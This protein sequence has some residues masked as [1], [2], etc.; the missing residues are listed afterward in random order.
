MKKQKWENDLFDDFDDLDD[1][2][3]D[4]GNISH[5]ATNDDC[6]LDDGDLFAIPEDKV[7]KVKLSNDKRIDILEALQKKGYSKE[8]SLKLYTASY[9]YLL[10]QSNNLWNIETIS[11]QID[12]LVNEF[13]SV[14]GFLK[15]ESA[16]SCTNN[17]DMPIRKYT[18]YDMPL[19]DIKDIL[20]YLTLTFS[21]S[22]NEIIEQLCSYPDWFFHKIPYFEKKIKYFQEFFRKDK[23]EIVNFCWNFPRIVGSRIDRLRKNTTEI[24]KHFHWDEIDFTSLLWQYP[25]LMNWS[26]L[27]FKK[28]NFDDRLFKKK[29]ILQLLLDSKTYLYGGYATFDDL[30]SYIEHIENIFGRMEKIIKVKFK[31]GI[32]QAI[33]FRNNNGEKF[34]VSV[35]ANHSTEKGRQTI[36]PTEKLLRLIFG[37]ENVPYIM[38]EFFCKLNKK[39]EDEELY[40]VALFRFIEE[41]GIYRVDFKPGTEFYSKSTEIIST[42]GISKYL[43]E[44]TNSSYDISMNAL[45]SPEQGK[46]RKYSPNKDNENNNV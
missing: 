45:Y 28:F 34:I 12:S 32:S 41:N 8:N 23:T 40:I 10:K 15:F 42:E 46:I 20:Q 6:Y 36:P 3:F 17:F 2:L 11:N 30:Y 1:L 24:C 14:D 4:D 33:A 37:E 26:V 9:D 22:K 38:N 43:G 35:G 19:G 7:S 21:K 44:M 25:S 5:N 29:W 16:Q 18:V 31:D 39:Y 27:Q 13:E